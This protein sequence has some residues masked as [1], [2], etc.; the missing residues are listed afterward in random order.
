MA[1]ASS[2]HGLVGA[3]GVDLDARRVLV[4]QGQRRIA[5]G[6]ELGQP[7][8]VHHRDFDGDDAER[9]A[10]GRSGG[11]RRMADD[12][13]AAGAVDDV[14]G[15]L[16]LLLQHRRD[17]A[18]RG[19]RAAARAPRADDGDGAVGPRALRPDAGKAEG[20]RST[21]RRASGQHIAARV[22]FCH[23]F[24][25]GWS[26]VHDTANAA[27]HHSVIPADA[28]T[29]CNGGHPPARLSRLSATAAAGMTG[30]LDRIN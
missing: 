7:L 27:R 20:H 21:G 29:R 1:S 23:R 12:A 9:V 24:L 19:V 17:D 6:L 28:A 22:S 30:R 3:A 25:R 4:H 13:R 10:V 2:L 11:D 14:E 16:E 5:V 18:R 8:P 26:F 15:L